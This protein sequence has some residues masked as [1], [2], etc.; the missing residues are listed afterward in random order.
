MFE[1]KQSDKLFI[2]TWQ[3]LQSATLVA[4]ELGLSIRHTQTRR[5]TIEDRYR[6]NLDST[7][8]QPQAKSGRA[9]Q[10]PGNMRREINLKDGMVVV[11]SDAHFWP[12]DPSPAY[13]ALLKFLETY[14][15]KIKVVVNNGDAFDGASI[16]RFPAQSWDKLPTVKEELDEIGRAHV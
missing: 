6:I 7:S 14:K 10:T 3:R 5:K 12:D 1:P 2:E 15:Q 9:A 4:K 11:F 8:T 16:S 13:R